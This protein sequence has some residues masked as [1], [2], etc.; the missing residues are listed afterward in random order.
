LADQMKDEQAETDRRLGDLDRSIADYLA[1]EGDAIGANV[2][3]T[4]GHGFKFASTDG[5]FSLNLGGLFDF[6]YMGVDRDRDEYPHLDNDQF[7]EYGYSKRDLNNIYLAEARWW[8]FGHAFD[9]ALTYY[10]EFYTQLSNNTYPEKAMDGLVEAQTVMPG[11]SSSYG[12]GNIALLDA[13][14]NWNICDWTNLKFGRFKVPISRQHLVHQSDLQ[15]GRRSLPFHATAGMNG[16]ALSYVSDLAAPIDRDDGIMF[17]DVLGVPWFGDFLADFKFEYAAGIFDGNLASTGSWVMPAWRVAIHPLGYLDYTEG[18]FRQVSDDPLVAFGASWYY[19]RGPEHMDR[20]Q[21][22]WG[23]DLAMSWYGFFMSGEWAYFKDD[24]RG[25]DSLHTRAWYIQGGYQVLPAELEIFARYGKVSWPF[26]LGLGNSTG[27]VL[28]TSDEWSVGAAYYWDQH[29]L[30]ALMEFG[31]T[32]VDWQDGPSR[33]HSTSHD[34]Y[35]DIDTW[36]LRLMF[37][38]E[39]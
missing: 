33:P 32:S 19:D 18:D 15:F 36:F 34:G 23:M 14:V 29:H 3:Y 12:D 20:A 13:W 10:F 28:D 38:L 37:Q 21:T 22:F 27:V 24:G 8:F 4:K 1:K 6:E 31:R 39:W 35:D 11:S 25:M 5:L 7:D 2:T 9:P 26:R 16:N 17:H 30:K